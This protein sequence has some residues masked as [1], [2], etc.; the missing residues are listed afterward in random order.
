MVGLA[1]G[2]TANQLVAL[3]KGKRGSPFVNKAD[4]KGKERWFIILE[5][6]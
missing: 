3:A 6:R 4:E 5:R 2:R 1:A